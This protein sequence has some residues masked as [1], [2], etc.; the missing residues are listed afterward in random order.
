LSAARRL[1]NCCA[2]SSKVIVM[3]SEDLKILVR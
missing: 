3:A 1:A 2:F